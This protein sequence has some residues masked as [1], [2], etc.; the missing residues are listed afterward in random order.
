MSKEI[1]TIS[2]KQSGP[3]LE[4]EFKATQANI[5]AYAE[6][7]SSEFILL[8]VFWARVR[9]TIKLTVAPFYEPSHSPII[10]PELLKN[11]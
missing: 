6:V 10:D 3:M 8:D 11:K 1:A 4:I 2:I 5:A 7:D 9:E